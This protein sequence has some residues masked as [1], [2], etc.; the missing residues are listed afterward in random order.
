MADF[1]QASD[2]K[3]WEKLQDHH[4]VLGRNIVLKEAF[5]KDPQRFEKFSRTFNNTADNSD[6][7][8]DFSKNFVT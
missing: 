4:T 7:L 6:T 2:L 8:F 1:A 5:Q 3:T